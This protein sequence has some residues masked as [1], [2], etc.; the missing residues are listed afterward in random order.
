M[1]EIIDI[2]TLFGPMPAAASDLS[3][4]ELAALMKRH[5]VSA[6]CTLSTVGLLLDHNSGNSA[7]RAACAENR[8]LIPVATINPLSFFGTEGP[9]L[10]FKQDGFR[11]VRFFPVAQCWDVE[12]A[13]F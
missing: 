10:R 4:E 6:G 3:V 12:H 5:S 2:N 8:A 11:L 9:H 1:S 13:A 7:T